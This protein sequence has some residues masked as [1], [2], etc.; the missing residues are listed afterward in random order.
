MR[1]LTPEE[2]AVLQWIAERRADMEALLVEVVNI[3]SGSYHKA[4]VDRVAAVFRAHLEAAGV[5]T[6]TVPVAEQGDNLIAEIPGHGVGAHALLLGHMDT[7]FPE[8]TVAA[9]PFRREG[10]RAF[11]PG[12]ADMKAGLVMNTFLIE[13][14]HALG[15]APM[16][17]KVLY[18]SDEEI[19]SPS[20]RSVIQACAEGAAMVLNAEPG[21]PNGNVVTARKGAL[22]FTLAVSGRAAH[23][24]V[25][26]A[27]GASAIE[28][29]ARKVLNLQALNRPGSETTVSVGL[30]KGGE[31]VNMVPA[32]ATAEVDVRFATIEAMEEVWRQ[33]LAIVDKEDLPGTAA[34]I[35]RKRN[36]LP[37]AQS[38]ASEAL[39]HAYVDCAR[40]LGMTV[41]GEATG[42][43][44]DSGFTAAVGA[45]TLCATGPVGGGAHSLD[46]FCDLDTLVPRAQA[47]A[48]TILRHGR[49]A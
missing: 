43:S 37:F 29:L 6:Q 12:V 35:T 11:G 44:A 26:P 42:G 13:A 5:P 3:D 18:S 4:G 22:F 31:S 45:P 23:A 30:I 25:E 2:G 21:R 27:K 15:G 17:L 24:G 8:G 47:V 14:F 36:F 7:V 20:S 16:P 19:A 10:D 9:R 46:E 33:I 40:D 32:C 38:S 39:F 49:A 1:D 41:H 28:A 48:L 34:R